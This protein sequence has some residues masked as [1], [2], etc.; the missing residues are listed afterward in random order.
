MWPPW[1]CLAVEPGVGGGLHALFGPGNGA[2]ALGVRGSSSLQRPL[3]CG[4]VEAGVVLPPAALLTPSAAS[5]GGCALSHRLI[6]FSSAQDEN[7][8]GISLLHPQHAALLTVMSGAWAPPTP[9]LQQG[10]HTLLGRAGTRC[11]EEG[12]ERPAQPAGL[13]FWCCHEQ[14]RLSVFG[15]SLLLHGVPLCCAVHIRLSWGW[16]G[17]G[18]LALSFP[19]RL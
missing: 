13:S 19:T 15:I 3:A 4:G 8:P 6:S 5:Q 10:W 16:G 14:P 1:P 17:G 2:A 7:G 18:R 9:P 11:W 12:P